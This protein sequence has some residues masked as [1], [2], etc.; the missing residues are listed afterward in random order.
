MADVEVPEHRD[1][2]NVRRASAKPDAGYR[3]PGT[4]T[5]V[6]SASQDCG[7]VFPEGRALAAGG[8]GEL[9]EPA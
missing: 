5:V 7:R 9:A 3:I 1:S 6:D 4:F 2:R 8:V